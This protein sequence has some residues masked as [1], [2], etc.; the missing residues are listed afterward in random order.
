MEPNKSL[1]IGSAVSFYFQSILDMGFAG[2]FFSLELS[3]LPHSIPLLAFTNA[4][5]HSED[6]I[7]R[8]SLVHIVLESLGDHKALFTHPLNAPR[9]I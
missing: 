6:V 1:S 3:D 8:R 4:E 9:G 5:G 7:K 2:Q